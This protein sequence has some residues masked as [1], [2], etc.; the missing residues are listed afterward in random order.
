MTPATIE[1]DQQK[2]TSYYEPSGS[3]T[4]VMVECFNEKANEAPDIPVEWRELDI[5]RHNIICAKPGGE[6]ER[7]AVYESTHSNF[8]EDIDNRINKDLN[9]PH[10]WKKEGFVE[11]N[12]VSK[13]NAKKVCMCLYYNYNLRP[14]IIVPNKEGGLTIFYKHY[15]NNRSLIVETYNTS[16]IAAIVND[17]TNKKN[18]GSEDIRDFDFESLVKILHE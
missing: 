12:T 16:E 14:R 15:N 13:D 7:L 10:S 5:Y 18:N 3:E 17:D 4:I 6:Y 9:F 1:Q 8:I 11:P 2:D